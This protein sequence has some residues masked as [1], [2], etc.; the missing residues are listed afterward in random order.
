MNHPRLFKLTSKGKPQFWDIATEGNVIVTRWGQLDGKVQETRD[1][2]AEG[3]NLGKTNETTPAEQADAEAL[4]QWEKKLKKGYVKTLASAEAGERDAVITGGID[5]MLAHSFAKSGDKIKYPAYSQPKF[6]GHRCIATVSG[7]KVS[8]WSRTRKP[9]TSM[10]HIQKAL[11]DLCLVDGVVFDGELYRHDYRNNFEALTSFIRDTKA[12]PGAEV[13]QYHIYDSAC[14]RDQ[15]SRTNTLEM[16]FI[17][18]PD[19]SPLVRV[20][21]DLVENEEELMARFEE[22]V[23]L[24]YEGAMV[25]NLYAKYENKRSYNLQKVKEFLDSEFKVIGVEEGRGK[26]AGHGIFVCQ[27]E[28]GEFRAK[29][30]GDIASLKQYWEKPELAVGRQLTVKYQGLTKLGIPRFPVAVRFRDDV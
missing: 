9:I 19:G 26:L 6:D 25:R 24:G 20:Q 8:L 21:T 16:V 23:A 1:V 3:K 22:Y 12:K 2:I 17:D 18:V 15:A 29:M 13:V 14:D 11:E 30:M 28:G 7:G 27:A 4:A 10:V 5:P